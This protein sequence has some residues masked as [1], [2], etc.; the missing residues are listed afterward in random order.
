MDEPIADEV[1]G[2]LDGHIVLDRS[3]AARGHYPAIDVV[4]SLSRVMDAVVAPEH[5]AAARK[6]RSLV[7]AYEEKR[8]LIALGAYSKGS[9][10]RVDQAV[11]ALPEIERF[12]QQSAADLAPFEHAI[13]ALKSL[14]APYR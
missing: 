6:V 14:S 10:P 1:R 4:S 7:A 2:I 5:L 8:D 11:F 13:A 9:D 3:I 12:L